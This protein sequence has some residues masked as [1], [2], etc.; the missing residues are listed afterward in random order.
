MP[1]EEYFRRTVLSALGG[2][3][4]MGGAAGFDG[5]GAND[6]L[7]GGTMALEQAYNVAGDLWIGPDSARSDVDAQDGRVYIGASGDGYTFYNGDGGNWSRKGLGDSANPVSSVTAESV[8]TEEAQTTKGYSR[9]FS[10]WNPHPIRGPE[11]S[12]PTLW[13]EH[14]AAENPL[15]SESEVASDFGLTNVTKIADPFIR[16]DPADGLWHQYYEIKDDTGT[17]IYHATSKDGYTWTNDE[18]VLANS[19]FS[20]TSSFA[21]PIFWKEPD[22]WYMLPD[23]DGDVVKLFAATSLQQDDWTEDQTVLDESYDIHDTTPFYIPEQDRWYAILSDE[24]NGKI[25]LFYADQGASFASVASSLTEHPSSPIADGKPTSTATY[26]PGGRPLVHDDGTVEVFFQ[27]DTGLSR[28]ISTHII[29]EI[30]TSAFSMSQATDN[31]TFVG[32]RG[33]DW[34][35]GCHHIDP[36][37]AHL[38]GQPIAIGDGLFEGGIYTGVL[39]PTNKPHGDVHMGLGSSH[40]VTGNQVPI[41]FSSPNRNHGYYWDESNNEYVAPRSGWYSFVVQIKYDSLV[42]ASTPFGSLIVIKNTTTGDDVAF[43]DEDITGNTNTGSQTQRAVN[44]QAYLNKGDKVLVR[45]TQDS[46]SDVPLSTANNQTFIDIT[47][48]L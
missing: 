14:P 16:H 25:R 27:D 21:F 31:P 48:K 19:N 2:L 24:T 43:S 4:A 35:G 47:P 42:S 17:N 30:T 41:P 10:G 39:T 6:N 45:A 22:G 20:W 36:T 9:D 44:H 26:K 15:F 1:D 37:I 46:G 38:T 18:Q 3:G 23:T 29:T 13:R 12:G 11:K 7:T 33:G 34:L 5:G 32:D 40:S 28:A 8:D